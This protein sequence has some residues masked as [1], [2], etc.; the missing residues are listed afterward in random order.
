M[1]YVYF[2]PSIYKL[3]SVCLSVCQPF[4]STLLTIFFKL[5]ISVD[6]WKKWFGIVDGYILSNKYSYGSWLFPLSMK[7]MFDQFSSNFAWE[8]I[9][10]RSPL[11][12]Q[13]GI[14]FK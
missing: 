10:V 2:I 13:M 3:L 5:C 12:L 1:E 11:G 4:V 6:I 8:F 7:G 9:L 14:F